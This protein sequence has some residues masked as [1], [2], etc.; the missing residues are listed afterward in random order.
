MN[1]PPMIEKFKFKKSIILIGILSILSFIP[2]TANSSSHVKI[3]LPQLKFETCL[4]YP[5]CSFYILDKSKE[6]AMRSG[7]RHDKIV[8]RIEPLVHMSY[9]RQCTR[10]TLGIGDFRQ[11]IWIDFAKKMMEADTISARGKKFRGMLL[12]DVI[13]DSQRSSDVVIRLI[14]DF[15]KGG[16]I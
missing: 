4:L 13:V 10:D 12:G 3:E 16:G 5:V 11:V 9:L 6:N 2:I 14:A 1:K 7:F 15:C 8:I